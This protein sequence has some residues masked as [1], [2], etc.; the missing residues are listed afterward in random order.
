MAQFNKPPKGCGMTLPNQFQSVPKEPVYHYRRNSLYSLSYQILKQIDGEMIPVGDY[1][2][3]DSSEDQRV[4][5]AKLINLVSLMNGNKTL[6]NAAKIAGK[7]LYFQMIPNNGQD[8]QQKIIFRERTG[9]GVT[10]EN[11]ILSLSE[12]L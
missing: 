7:A 3:L 11:A 10:T 2:V 5:E 1:A 12:E 9:N 6:S 4:T 8:A